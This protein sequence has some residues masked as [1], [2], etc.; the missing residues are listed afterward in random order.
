[1]SL[2][3][4]AIAEA[5]K[6]Q[7]LAEVSREVNIYTNEPWEFKFPCI[8]INL[9]SDLNYHGSSGSKPLAEFDLDLEVRVSAAMVDSG[10][11]I[12]DYLSSGA[13]KTSSIHDA[14]MAG[15]DPA[16][17]DTLGGLVED[18]YVLTASQPTWIV[19][20]ARQISYRSAVVKCHVLTRPA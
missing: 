10:I 12:N 1:M 7:L 17:N 8:V 11:A 14:M 9:G 19:D 13:G 20:T 2:D 6:V 15:R 18:C 5:I 4:Q 3:L 16:E